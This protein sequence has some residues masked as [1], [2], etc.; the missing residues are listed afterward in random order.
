MSSIFAPKQSKNL[1]LNMK[2]KKTPDLISESFHLPFTQHHPESL[3]NQNHAGKV[4]VNVEEQA[5]GQRVTTG[6]SW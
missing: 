3:P 6:S 4:T 1:C 5:D 2:P